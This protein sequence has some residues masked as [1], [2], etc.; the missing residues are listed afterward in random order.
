MRSRSFGSRSSARASSEKIT[1]CGIGKSADQLTAV[2]D[3]EYWS[4]PREGGGPP[5]AAGPHRSAE[6]AGQVDAAAVVAAPTSDHAEA[7]AAACWRPAS[8]CSW[9][10]PS[11]P[12]SRRPTA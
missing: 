5:P 8:T 4:A 7:S 2:V 12:T 3:H 6:L 10:S 1:P 11:P 9:K